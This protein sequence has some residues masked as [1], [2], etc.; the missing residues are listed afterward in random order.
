MRKKSAEIH[1]L[2]TE[3]GPNFSY[4]PDEDL[5]LELKNSDVTEEEGKETALLLR[6]PQILPHRCVS[7]VPD[8]P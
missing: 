8:S 7:A 5:G 4:S 2:L 6:G 3:M 1:S